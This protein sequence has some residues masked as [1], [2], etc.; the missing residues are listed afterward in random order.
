MAKVVDVTL[1]LIDQLS[2]PLNKAGQKLAEHANQWKRAG[3][4]I[5]SVGG[6]IAKV[7]SNMTK[8][9]TVPVL[10][11]GTAAFIISASCKVVAIG[12]FSLSLIIALVICLANF[13]SP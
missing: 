13:S 8:K 12:C 1:R 7:G 5:A 3:T 4:Q 9:I 11:A 10:A 2:S 6:K